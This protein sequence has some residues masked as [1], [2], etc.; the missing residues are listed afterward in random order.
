M[1]PTDQ[2]TWA[3]ADDTAKSAATAKALVAASL[4]NPER[5]KIK[6]IPERAAKT[7]PCSRQRATREPRRRLIHEKVAK[8]H[9]AVGGSIHE[10]TSWPRQIWTGG[11]KPK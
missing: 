1:T 11:E 8:R 6:G 10:K 5:L 9:E 4:K 2:F 3:F 7:A